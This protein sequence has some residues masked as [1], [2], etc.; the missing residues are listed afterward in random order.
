MPVKRCHYLKADGT[1]CQS[2]PL[3]GEKY[4][5]SHLRFKGRPVR[6]WRGRRSD[7]PDRLLV[8]PPKDLREHQIRLTRVIQAVAE[9]RMDLDRAGRVL[10]ALEQ[11]GAKL[12]AAAA[13]DAGLSQQQ[14]PAEPEGEEEQFVPKLGKDGQLY[15]EDKSFG[16]KIVI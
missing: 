4:C 16:I 6:T 11:I 12:R 2:P 3:R 5:H 13:R 9:N 8:P 1:S 15:L 10:Y 7:T 14:L